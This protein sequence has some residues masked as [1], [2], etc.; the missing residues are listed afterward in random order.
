[1]IFFV[2]VYLKIWVLEI[3]INIITFPK[4][5]LVFLRY[6]KVVKCS[7]CSSMEKFFFY[8]GANLVLLLFTLLLIQ[9]YSL[10]M[11]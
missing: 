8:P 2:L 4:V 10:N 9:Y 7:S 3:I 6:N 1:M 5:K 11:R